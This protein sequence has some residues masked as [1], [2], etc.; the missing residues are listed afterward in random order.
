MLVTMSEAYKMAQLRG[1]SLDANK[2]IYLATLG[3]AEA[4][5]IDDRVGSLQPGMAADIAV[6]DPKATPLLQLRADV[7]EREL[8]GTALRVDYLRRRSRGGSDL[9]RGR[10]A[11]RTRIGFSDL[12]ARKRNM[13]RP[14]HPKP[15]HRIIAIV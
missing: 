8:Y 5:G 10:S 14:V 12:H 3:S 1:I 2:L 15:R 7:A 11:L 13:I 9:C 4:L 6:L